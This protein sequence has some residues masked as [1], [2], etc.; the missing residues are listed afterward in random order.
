MNRWMHQLPEKCPNMIGKLESGKLRMPLESN[1]SRYLT[2][3]KW[4][5][6][7]ANEITNSPDGTKSCWFVNSTKKDGT[8]T[9]K[10]SSTGGRDKY[11]TSRVMKVLQCPNYRELVELK[12]TKLNY[13]FVHI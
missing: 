10:I 12:D 7:R 1:D 4:I 9:I 8:H 5:N 6:A 11:Q 13:H 3:K 2:W